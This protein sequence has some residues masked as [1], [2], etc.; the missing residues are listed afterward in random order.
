MAL[1]LA[2]ERA[3]AISP[4]RKPV[5]CRGVQCRVLAVTSTLMG[6]NERSGVR[7]SL[8]PKIWCFVVIIAPPTVLRSG[9]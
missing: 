4:V 6:M 1:G 3:C 9:W 7:F 2:P 8:R 5:G